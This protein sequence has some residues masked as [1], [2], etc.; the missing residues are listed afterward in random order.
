M[1]LLLLSIVLYL[2]LLPVW[3]Y[4]LQ[5][6][7]YIAGVSANWIYGFFDASVSIKPDGRVVRVIV[8]GQAVAEAQ[9]YSSAL[10]LDTVTYGIPMLAAL[11]LATHT[12]SLIAKLRP[13]LTGLAVMAVLTVPAVMAWAKLATL[14]ADERIVESGGRSSFL[15]Y[16]FH[17][18]AFSQ[19]VV[20]VALW[21]G[22][23]M[24]GMFN[25]GRK[26]SRTVAVARNA[27]CPCGSG[28]KYKKCCGAR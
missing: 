7:A 6:L 22:M 8:S 2:A 9:P 12:D 24:L 23:L 1:R 26:Q 3:W 21:L 11:V 13:L 10:R 19:P 15:F 17:G 4:S 16:A 20:A 27:A 28:R 14:Q 25:L 18:Y 5:A